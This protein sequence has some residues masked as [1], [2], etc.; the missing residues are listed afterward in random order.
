[1][2]GQCRNGSVNKTVVLTATSAPLLPKEKIRSACPADADAEETCRD[3]IVIHGIPNLE[4][5]GLWFESYLGE[6]LFED[7]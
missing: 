3:G 5:G 1:M 6:F 4:T 2:A 7:S